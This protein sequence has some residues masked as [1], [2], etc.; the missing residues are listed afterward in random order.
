MNGES[1][2][3]DLNDE[4]S[5]DYVQ[6]F[7]RIEDFVVDFRKRFD[8]ILAYHATVLDS[9][10]RKSIEQN[11]LNVA[12]VN[13]LRKKA[14]ARF[15]WETDK[16]ETQIAIV[17]E[18]NDYFKSTPPITIGEINFGLDEEKLLTDCCQ[19]LFFGPEV[20]LP[21]ADNLTD[22]FHTSFRQR[23]MGFGESYIIKVKVPTEHTKSLWIE[24]VFE[25]WVN[26]WPEASLVYHHNLPNANI[27]DL[28]QV[29]KPYNRYGIPLY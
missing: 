28:K 19:Y 2:T 14:L 11:G 21:L 5:I 23:M 8:H 18:I 4:D 24:N 16:A 17:S 20:L 26:G 22:K 12:S 10:E 7:T 6:S 13:L 3:Y 29:E 15:V 9:S 25:Y 1:K 27:V